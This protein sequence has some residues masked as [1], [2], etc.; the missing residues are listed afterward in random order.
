MKKT[1]KKLA[2]HRETVKHLSQETLGPVAG[3]S[4]AIICQSR[5][6]IIISDIPGGCDIETTFC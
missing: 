3:A 5:T 4:N 6:Y 1:V 2:L